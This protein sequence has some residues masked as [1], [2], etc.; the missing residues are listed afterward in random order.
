M[1][2]CRICPSWPEYVVSDDGRIR[3]AV[4]RGSADARERKPFL[5]TNGYL[6]I[7]MRHNGK[8][9]SVGVHRI[10]AEAFLGSPPS[11]SH[12]VAHADGDRTN[13]RVSNLRYATR[14]ENE[15]DK[16]AHGRTNRGERCG[17]ARLT[18][19]AVR[20]IRAALDS[21]EKQAEVAARFGTDQRNVSNIKR[22]VSWAWL[23]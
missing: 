23:A 19:E 11:G 4:K 20:A 15:G 3:R 1:S 21:G 2:A 13:N 10:V 18:E 5:S 7:A 14:A 22:R 8:T 17:R 16:V 12:Q 6:Y 9:Q